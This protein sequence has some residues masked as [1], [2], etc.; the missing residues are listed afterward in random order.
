WVVAGAGFPKMQI[1]GFDCCAP[2]P[3]VLAAALPSSATNSRRP[4][5]D[6]GG[7]SLRDYRSVS[8][9][10]REPVGLRGGSLNCSESDLGNL[11]AGRTPGRLHDRH[12]NQGCSEGTQKMR[13]I[14]RV[15]GGK[16]PKGTGSTTSGPIKI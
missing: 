12:P 3:S 11:P 4:M 1:T 15:K 6:M 9:P 2:A 14:A 10:P 8:L 5:P 16:S 13:S 7:P